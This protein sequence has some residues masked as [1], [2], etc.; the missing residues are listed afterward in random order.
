MERLAQIEQLIEMGREEGQ[1]RVAERARDAVEALE[2]GL[3]V[4][5]STVLERVRPRSRR[6]PGTLQLLLVAVAVATV[7]AIAGFVIARLVQRGRASGRRRVG[8]APV[9]IPVVSHVNATRD[10]E[11]VGRQEEPSEALA[12]S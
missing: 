6:G 3:D 12:A 7:T 1:R 8:S 2:G 9:A 4:A 10:V 11:A 5:V